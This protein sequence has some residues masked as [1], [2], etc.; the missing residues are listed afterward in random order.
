MDPQTLSAACSHNLHG[1]CD[2]KI[3]MGLH[4]FLNIK[5]SIS[6]IPHQCAPLNS[7]FGVSNVFQIDTSPGRSLDRVSFLIG[8]RLGASLIALCIVGPSRLG[9]PVLFQMRLPSERS[10]H[11]HRPEL[12]I[13]IVRGL[14]GKQDPP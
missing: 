8:K 7:Q 9:F 13:N 3:G 14:A 10:S 5:P 4:E 1:K 6:V 2:Q 12:K 11:E